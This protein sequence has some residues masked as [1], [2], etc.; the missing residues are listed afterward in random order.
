M[1][2]KLTPHAPQVSRTTYQAG[3]VIVSTSQSTV[4]TS[5]ILIF[6]HLRCVGG[7]SGSTVPVTTLASDDGT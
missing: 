1:G 7:P 3:E 6:F 4:L 5:E 2:L